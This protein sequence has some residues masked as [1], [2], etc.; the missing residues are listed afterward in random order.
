ME[1]SSSE[2][3]AINCKNATVMGSG[4]A[5]R[6][7]MVILPM[8]WRRICFTLIT[9]TILQNCWTDLDRRD[10]SVMITVSPG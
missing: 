9:S 6:Q 8:I 5:V 7:S 4:S 10:G 1:S 3:T 2:K